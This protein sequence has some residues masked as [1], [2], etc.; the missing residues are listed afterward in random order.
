[1]QA[2]PYESTDIQGQQTLPYNRI[3]LTPIKYMQ[4][5]Y[6]MMGEQ[7]FLFLGITVCALLIGSIVPFGILFG[8]MLAG[9]YLCF[10]QKESGTP[11]KFETLFQGFEHFVPTMLVMLT[12]IL[13]NLLFTVTIMA[14]TFLAVIIAAPIVGNGSANGPPAS[15]VAIGFATGYI[16]LVLGSFLTFVPFTF[17]F[18]LIAEHKLPAGTA[19]QTSAR[20]ALHNL[21]PLLAIF[22]CLSFCGLVAALFCYIP[23]FF[24]MPLQIGAMFVLYR[25]TFPKVSDNETK[26]PFP[27]SP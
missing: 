16:A 10:L 23:L 17:C 3:A 24:L 2:N 15:V 18:Q 11:V 7:Y 5:A 19:M 22:I 9:I 14:L 20:A 26:L 27:G 1:M 8:P 13:C 12:A 21:F 6:R 4:R 25:D